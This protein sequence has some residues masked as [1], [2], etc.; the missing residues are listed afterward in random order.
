MLAAGD[1]IIASSSQAAA[2]TSTATPI[3]LFAL[4]KKIGEGGYGIVYK[5]TRATAVSEF[6]Y[7]VKVLDPS[8]FVT[9]YEKAV[10]RFKREVQA[11]QLL[12]HRAI[13]PYYEAGIT[14]DQ[15]PYVVCRSSMERI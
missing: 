11:L 14:G 1:A 7:A 9:D 12:Q 13:V 10:K 2:G 6:I 3:P 8:P 5:A 4:G 15:K